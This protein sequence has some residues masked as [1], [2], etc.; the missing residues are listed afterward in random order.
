[1]L[2]YLSEN[3]VSIGGLFNAESW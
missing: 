1:M 2:Y 3:A